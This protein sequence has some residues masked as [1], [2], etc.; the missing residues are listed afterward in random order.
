VGKRDYRTGP[1]PNALAIGDLNG[2]HKLDLV[3]ANLGYEGNTVSVL[4]NRGSGTFRRKRDYRTGGTDGVVIGDLNGDRKPDIAT[5]NGNN[6]A[7]VSVLANRGDGRFP[8]KL[9]Y[10]AP[11]AFS[12]AM[13]D[14]N[15][16]GELDLAGSNTDANTISVLINTP[17]LCVVQDVRRMTLRVATRMLARVN[18]QV[19]EVGSD[20]SRYFKRGRVMWQKPGPG[21][22]RPNRTT[23]DVVLSVGP[24]G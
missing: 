3:V 24:K 17:G 20:H 14:V 7:T 11:G 12:L 13:G 4:Q 1:G 15:G 22:V 8:R 5:A 2:D 9:D 6:A 16:D 18:C 19:G 23:V 10:R 21:A